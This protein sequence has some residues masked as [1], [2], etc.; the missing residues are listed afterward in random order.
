MQYSLSGFQKSRR[1]NSTFGVRLFSAADA[2]NRVTT[3]NQY[4]IVK[5]HLGRD[6]ARCCCYK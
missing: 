6:V 1:D 4:I 2:M 5:Q 3:E